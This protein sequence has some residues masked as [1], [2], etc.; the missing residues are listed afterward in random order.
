MVTEL[1]IIHVTDEDEIE[2]GNEDDDLADDGEDHNQSVKW[3]VMFSFFFPIT[4]LMLKLWMVDHLISLTSLNFV[5]F[6]L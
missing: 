3:E 4:T 1:I 2:L 6:F 5:I